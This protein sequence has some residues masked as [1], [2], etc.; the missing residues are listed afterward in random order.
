MEITQVSILDTTE[1]LIL[2]PFSLLLRVLGHTLL[3]PGPRFRRNLFSFGVSEWL[4][5]P[6]LG[7]IE[8]LLYT[9]S[10]P[11]VFEPLC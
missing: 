6:R 9:L 10:S 2:A 8:A 7:D 1:T 11:E 3:Y 5:V 4:G